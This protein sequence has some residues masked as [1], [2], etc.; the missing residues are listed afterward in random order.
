MKPRFIELYLD[1]AKRTAQMSHAKRLKVGALCV[2]D[3]NILG[4]SWNGT[5]RGWDN[6]CEDENNKTKDIVIHAEAN[7]IDK[8]ARQGGIG[9]KDSIMFITHA[10]CVPCAVDIIQAGITTVYYAEDY[11]D[12]HG[13]E[14]LREGGVE[15][16]KWPPSQE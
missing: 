2:K 14:R 12:L 11:R 5:P 8:V 7:V 13:V 15:V 6:C 10:P 4:Y 1:I 9:L 16:I 3:D